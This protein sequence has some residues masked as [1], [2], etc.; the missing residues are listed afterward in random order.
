MHTEKPVTLNLQKELKLSKKAAQ[1]ADDLIERS[2]QYFPN[3][4]VSLNKEATEI[5]SKDGI[6]TIK[7]NNNNPY[8]GGGGESWILTDPTIIWNPKGGYS[9]PSLIGIPNKI[10]PITTIYE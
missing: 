1:E 8:E 4:D 6:K 5:L 7:Y 10:L 2:K 3:K 9:L